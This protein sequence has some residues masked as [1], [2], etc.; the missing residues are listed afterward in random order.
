MHCSP[1][2]DG[3]GTETVQGGAAS[4]P[5]AATRSGRLNPMTESEGQLAPYQ[6][7]HTPRRVAKWVALRCIADAP[8]WEFEGYLERPLV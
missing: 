1:Q 6:K 2:N 5:S 4:D 3:D 7:R 8:A